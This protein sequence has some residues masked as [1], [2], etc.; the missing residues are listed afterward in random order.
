M[1][2]KDTLVSPKLFSFIF[3]SSIQS[4]QVSNANMHKAKWANKYSSYFFTDPEVF[5]SL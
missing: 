1:Q 4:S 3:A 5:I 2:Q